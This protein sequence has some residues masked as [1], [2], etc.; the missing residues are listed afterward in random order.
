ML[1]KDPGGADALKFTNLASRL[2]KQVRSCAAWPRPFDDI[3]NCLQSVISKQTE[4]VSFLAAMSRTP[5]S[6]RPPTSHS[7]LTTSQSKSRQPSIRTPTLPVPPPL[8][9]AAG[10]SKA[11]LLKEWRKSKG[12]TPISEV[13]LLRDAIY[14]LQGISGTYIKFSQEENDDRIIFLDDPVSNRALLSL[15]CSHTLRTTPSLPQRKC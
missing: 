14:L 10:K 5:S 11:E 2:H 4:I 12:Q 6:S 15:L 9:S 13:Q 7:R 8:P 1:L 3:P